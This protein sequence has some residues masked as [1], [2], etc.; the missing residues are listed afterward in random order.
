MSLLNAYLL[1]A[2]FRLHL[3]QRLVRLQTL[4]D[5]SVILQGQGR[6]PFPELPRQRGIS[7]RLEIRTRGDFLLSSRR[8]RRPR[9]KKIKLFFLR[10]MSHFPRTHFLLSRRTHFPQ[11]SSKDICSLLYQSSSAFES[12]CLSYTRLLIFAATLSFQG[13]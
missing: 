13:A 6:F 3:T 12:N 2:I 5:E 8:L 1:P 7:G 9:K 4:L 11:F 10:F